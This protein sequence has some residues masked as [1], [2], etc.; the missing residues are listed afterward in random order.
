M[1]THTNARGGEHHRD[2]RLVAGPNPTQFY[3]ACI[4]ACNQGE[5]AYLQIAGGQEGLTTLALPHLLTLA[6]HQSGAKSDERTC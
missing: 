3:Y 1:N 5:I 2:D 4:A 6:H